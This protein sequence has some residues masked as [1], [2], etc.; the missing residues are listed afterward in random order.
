MDRPGWSEYFLDI[1]K[2]VARR[3]TCL[4]R[5]YGAVLVQDEKIVSTGYN[6]PPRGEDHCKL[7]LRQQLNIP[8]GERYELCRA[9]HAE[10][11]ALLFA[12]PEKFKGATLFLAGFDSQTGD[13]IKAAPCKICSNLIKNT[14]V[15]VITE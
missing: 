1:A 5:K 12:D 6:G 14:G 9:V 15:K 3:A 11:N 7:C 8:Q 10:Q 4:R 13:P 2:M